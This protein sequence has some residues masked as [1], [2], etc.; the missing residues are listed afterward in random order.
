MEKPISAATNVTLKFTQA[1]ND[2]PVNILFSG[3]FGKQR[4][5]GDDERLSNT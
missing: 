3:P 4:G 5:G 1:N 2:Q